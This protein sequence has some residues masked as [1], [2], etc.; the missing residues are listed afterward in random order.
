VRIVLKIVE[1]ARSTYYYWRSLKDRRG[2]TKESRQG[3]RPK[4][5]F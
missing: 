5:G 1:V 4:M 3:K 2:I